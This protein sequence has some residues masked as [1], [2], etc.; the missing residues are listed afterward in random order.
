MSVIKTIYCLTMGSMAG[1]L[2]Q[3]GGKPIL[4]LA[5]APKTL[6]TA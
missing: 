6:G 5:I 1:A 3:T 2:N 4:Y